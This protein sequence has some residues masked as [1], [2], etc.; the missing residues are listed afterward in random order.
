MFYKFKFCIEVTIKI[1]TFNSGFI[2]IHPPLHSPQS[3]IFIHSL[4]LRSVLWLYTKKNERE[5]RGVCL[6]VCLFVYILLN[7]KEVSSVCFIHLRLRISN[8]FLLIIN[9]VFFQLRCFTDKPTTIIDN[10][11]SI[12]SY[13]KINFW[14][15]IDI[16]VIDDRKVISTWWL[17]GVW[18]A[19]N[20][21]C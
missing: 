16:S 14:L 17:S 18:A 1:D 6:S 2:H 11:L 12:I 15:H 10:K 5:R 3:Y 8:F 7:S 9:F 20:Q 19:L 21:I 4:R 13:N